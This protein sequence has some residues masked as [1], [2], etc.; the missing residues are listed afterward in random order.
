MWIHPENSNTI[1]TSTTPTSPQQQQVYANQVFHL[2]GMGLYRQLEGLHSSMLTISK[3]DVPTDGEEAN[4]N[5][6]SIHPD[7]GGALRVH[8][9]D[10]LDMVWDSWSALLSVVDTTKR[11]SSLSTCSGTD[12]AVDEVLSAMITIVA[13]AL[14]GSLDTTINSG[15]NGG[16]NSSLEAALLKLKVVGSAEEASILVSTKYNPCSTDKKITEAVVML[17]HV[18]SRTL[19]QLKDDVDLSFALGLLLLHPG[20]ESLRSKAHCVDIV[21]C[22]RELLTSFAFGMDKLCTNSDIH[23]SSSRCRTSLTLRDS[24]LKSMATIR[25]GAAADASTQKH[26]LREITEDIF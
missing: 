16:V 12:S 8:G 1:K 6:P 13:A 18:Q 9:D 19:Q 23:P 22:R 15:S 26:K 24:Y 3:G 20:D 4:F 5:S 25:K 17:S 10:I 21:K 14:Q 7:D 11:A 2:V